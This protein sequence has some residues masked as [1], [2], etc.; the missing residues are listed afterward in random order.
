MSRV[1]VRAPSAVKSL[2]DPRSD[3]FAMPSGETKMFS[4]FMS[5]CIVSFE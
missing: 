3:I 1:V 5:P 2:A 4:S